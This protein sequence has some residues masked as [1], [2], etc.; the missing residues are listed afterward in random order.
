MLLEIATGIAIAG[1]IFEYI[2]ITV[3]NDDVNKLQRQI[4]NLKQKIDDMTRQIY[5]ST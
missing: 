1:V 3:V 2:L 4:T 5:D